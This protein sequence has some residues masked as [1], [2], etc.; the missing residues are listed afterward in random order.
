M[1]VGTGRVVVRSACVNAVLLS[2]RAGDGKRGERR[3]KGDDEKEKEI[4]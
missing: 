3:R 4:K 2:M 1:R